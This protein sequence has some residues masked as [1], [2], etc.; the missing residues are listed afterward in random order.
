M[1]MLWMLVL[2]WD[3]SYQNQVWIWFVL[4]RP[5][6]CIQLTYLSL[7]QYHL[8]YTE[9]QSTDCIIESIELLLVEFLNQKSFITIRLSWLFSLERKV[10]GTALDLQNKEQ[11]TG[12]IYL[13]IQATII[14]YQ[15]HSKCTLQPMIDEVL[16]PCFFFTHLVMKC[17]QIFLLDVLD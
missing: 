16:L 17:H 15:L 9:L 2:R 6:P 3:I 13:W 11:P 10:N 14:I 4:S 5:P 7:R 1:W 8:V 12:L